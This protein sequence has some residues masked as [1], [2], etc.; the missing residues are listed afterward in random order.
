MLARG[1][2]TWLFRPSRSSPVWHSRDISSDCT[3]EA[4]LAFLS[5]LKHL[6]FTFK[7]SMFLLRP[8]SSQGTDHAI[9]QTASLQRSSF[10]TCLRQRSPFALLFTRLQ[11]WCGEAAVHVATHAS[12]S[13]D[14]V[15]AAFTTTWS[16]R[17][18]ADRICFIE[19]TTKLETFRDIGQS[20]KIAYTT[21]SACIS[22]H[23]SICTHTHVR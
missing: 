14:I 6:T 8:R 15:P 13:F 12:S 11:R 21:C 4:S 3:A 1:G 17:R 22:V 16:P 19:T 23:S 9:L 18:S 5:P 20:V 7:G 10:R 2:G